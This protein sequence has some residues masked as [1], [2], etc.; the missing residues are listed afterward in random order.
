MNAPEILTQ[1][2]DKTACSK[3]LDMGNKAVV[4]TLDTVNAGRDQREWWHICS[5]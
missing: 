2:F 4:P 5:P 1:A 3:G